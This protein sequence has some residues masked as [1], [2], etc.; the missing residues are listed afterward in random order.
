MCVCCCCFDIYFVESR[1]CLC[2]RVLRIS[3]DC[4]FSIDF[5]VCSWLSILENSL[6]LFGLHLH[7]YAACININMFIFYL[8]LKLGT[9]I[10]INLRIL[11]EKNVQERK[12]ATP[13][14]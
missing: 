9:K 10:E 4:F 12:F 6:N 7:A 2:V 5:L 11:E 13:K 8:N 3:L 1:S 14:K